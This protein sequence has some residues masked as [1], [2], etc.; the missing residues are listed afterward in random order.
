MTSEEMIACPYCGGAVPA[1]V[2]ICPSCQ[3]DLA[4]LIK[5]R[6]LHVIHYNEAL[7]LARSGQLEQAQARA[8]LAVEARPEF[9]PAH[10]LLAK[11]HARQGRWSQARGSLEQAQE[12]L[13]D[14]PTLDELAQAIAAG[15]QADAERAQAE[16]ARAATEAARDQAEDRAR[17]RAATA[18]PDATTTRPD[19]VRPGPDTEPPQAEAAPA[20]ADTERATADAALSEP[21]AAQPVAAPVASQSPARRTTPAARAIAEQQLDIYERDVTRAFGLGAAAVG[22][23]ALLWRLFFG[24]RHD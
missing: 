13:P 24:R 15:S 11:L 20:R 16:A 21:D 4:A 5:L 8:E 23:L 6:N 17:V 12:L 18:Q 7:V 14:D 10:L 1:D 3:E 9:A 19:A 22:G 2:T